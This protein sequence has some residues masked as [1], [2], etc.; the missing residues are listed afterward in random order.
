MPDPSSVISRVS[1]MPSIVETTPRTKRRHSL[2]ALAGLIS[3]GLIALIVGLLDWI[4]LPELPINLNIGIAG[5]EAEVLVA[6]AIAAEVW[7]SYLERIDKPA[8]GMS[9]PP[10]QPP[11][12]TTPQAPPPTQ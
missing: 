4:Y 2:T 1:P 12:P 8:V 10:P 5:V 3:I 11:P 6:V 9:T 7:L